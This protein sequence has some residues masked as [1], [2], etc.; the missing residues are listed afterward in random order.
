M[1]SKSKFLYILTIMKYSENRRN[2]DSITHF[3]NIFVFII[4]QYSTE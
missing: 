1:K 3:R 4:Q 2:Y